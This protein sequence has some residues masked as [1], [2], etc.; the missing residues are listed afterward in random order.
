MKKPKNFIFLVILLI[1]SQIDFSAIKVLIIASGENFIQQSISKLPNAKDDAEKFS[2]ILINSGFA[3]KDEIEFILNPSLSILKTALPRT[4]KNLT[5][6]DIFVF[7]YGGHAFTNE[8]NQDLYLIPTDFD[9]RYKQETSYNLTEDLSSLLYNLQI[10]SGLIIIDS[11][12]SGIIAGRPIENLNIEEKNLLKIAKNNNINFLLSSSANEISREKNEGG[13]LF[14]YWLIRALQGE[15]KKNR[16]DPWLYLEEI[17]EFV[18]EN[19]NKESRGMQTPKF[20]KNNDFAW[21]KIEEIEKEI[22][23]MNIHTTLTELL[24]EEK[25]Q[26]THFDKTIK[27]LYQEEKKDENEQEKLIREYLYEYLAK[28]KKEEFLKLITNLIPINLPPEKA[29]RKNQDE[30]EEQEIKL[31]LQWECSD[32]END[33]IRYK[34][35]FGKTENPNLYRENIKE[36][37]I[38]VENLEYL[39]TY[40]WSIESS[41]SFGNSSQS[42][43]WK[44]KTKDEA[45]KIQIAITT[46]QKDVSIKINDVDYGIAPLKIELEEG[47]HTIKAIKT[48]YKEKEHILELKDATIKEQKNIKIEMDLEQIIAEL[49]ISSTPLQ[50]EVYINSKFSGVTPLTNNLVYGTYDIEIKYPQYENYKKQIQIQNEE[51]IKIETVLMPLTSEITFK[52]NPDNAAIFINDRYEGKT[53]LTIKLPSGDYNLN[54]SKNNHRDMNYKYIVSY[55]D[56]DKKKEMTFN[57]IEKKHV[58]H[59]MIEINASPFQMGNDSGNGSDLERPM[60]QVTLNYPYLIGKYEITFNDYDEFCESVGKAKPFDR[61]WGRGIRPVININWWDATEY[62]NWLSIQEGIPTAYDKS[63]NLLDENGNF[64][65]DITLV[66]GYRLPTEAEWE[67]AALAQTNHIDAIAWYSNNSESKTQ[68]IGKKEANEF[69][70]HDMIGNVWEWVH[71]WIDLYDLQPKTNPTGTVLGSYKTIRGGGWDSQTNLLTK[72]TRGYALPRNYANNLGFRIAKSK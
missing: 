66:K 4:I 22:I 17:Y 46:V 34:L 72:S 70:I 55:D 14:S 1:I 36:T 44:F 47:K 24:S 58:K 49:S 64:T 5:Q 15:A 69:G 7:Y 28:S 62:C 13:G 16:D 12:Y 54:I 56:L 71:N 59:E 21:I 25:I 29:I 37:T 6:N 8:I 35:F 63:G 41:D 23:K 30:N 48:G 43:I 38:K 50:S 67:Y 65:N 33:E 10:A 39:T 32:P 45:K 18:K 57:L 11:C 60:H 40:Y 31:E 68:E 27:I 3:Q 51:K 20:I 19:V 42:E 2:K 9:E 52:S 61:N 26:K 53:P